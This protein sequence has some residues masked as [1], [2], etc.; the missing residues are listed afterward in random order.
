[1]GSE[2]IYKK[3]LND[4]SEIP[5]GPSTFEDICHILMKIKYPKYNFT[6]PS[7]GKGT[8]DG[9]RDGYDQLLKVKF[10]C[11]LDKD[12][13]T[14]IKKEVQVSKINGD[15]QL[16]YLSNQNI[17]DIEKNEIKADPVNTGIDLIIFGIGDLSQDIENICK[18][19]YV[20]ELY[21]LLCLDFL[22]IGE[23]YQR[24]DARPVTINYN[25]NDYKKRVVIIDKDIKFIN[26]FNNEQISENP[27]LD[28]LFS[29]CFNKEISVVKNIAFCGVGYLGKSFL[30]QKTYNTLI[31]VFSD[32]NNYS[33][34]HYIPFIKYFELKYYKQGIIEREIKNNIDP[35]LLFLDGLD[36]LNESTR[37]VLNKELHSIY[38]ANNRVRFIISGRNSSFIDFD[39]INSS[40][41]LFLEK[42]SDPY[43]Y[44]LLDLMNEY[45]NTPIADLLPIPT[46]R[47]YVVE[48]K[49][50]KD[51]KFHEFNNLLIIDNLKKDKERRDI[52]EEISARITSENNIDAVIE[53]LSNFCYKLFINK[54][55]VFTENELR[56]EIGNDKIFIL[57]IH[58]SIISFQDKDNIS[59]VSNF[60]FEYFVSNALLTKSRKTIYKI[61]VS[62]GKIKIPLIDILVLFIN[63]AQTKS[64]LLYKY[65]MKKIL[66]DNI[67]YILLCEFDSLTDKDRYE[68]F[69][70][71]FNKY[72][73]EKRS[74]YY[75]RFQPKYGP[76]KNIDNMAL[77]MQQLL[78]SMYKKNAINILISE[79]NNYLG[80]PQKDNEISFE[81]A[82]ILLVSF[83]KYKWLESE[84]VELK[85]IAIPL[86]R[87]LLNEKVFN[88][89][90]GFI[91]EEYI[92]D[93]YK[94]YNWIEGWK[95]EEWELFYLNISGRICSLLYDV[96]D[97]YDFSIKFN[98]YHCFQ[99]NNSIKE[100]LFPLLRY[101]MINKFQSGY[102]LARTV[103][104]ML[105]D[106]DYA[107]VLRTDDRIYTLTRFVEIEKLNVTEILE[108]LIFS[109]DNKI[110]SKI[111]DHYN[112][113][114]S[115]LENKLFN[116]IESIK[117]ENCELFSKYYLQTDEFK[118]SNKLFDEGIKNKNE[119]LNKYLV[120]N[121]IDKK[122][123]KW[124]VGYFLCN[125]IDFINE[126]QSLLYLNI[127]KEKSTEKIYVD[128]IYY[129]F[130]SKEHILKRN[131]V[132]INEY[133]KIFENEILKENEKKKNI[134]NKKNEIQLKNNNDISLILNQ[135]ELIEEL[136]K[137]NSYIDDYEI[138]RKER[139][140][141]GKLISLYHS[142]I[143][144]TI[145]YEFER[146]VPPV[147]SECAINIFENFYRS[148]IY[149][150][151][152]I[153]KI[154]KEFYFQE[155][156]FYIYFYWF[157]IKRHRKEQNSNEEAKDVLI[158]DDIKR[159]IIYSINNDVS[160]IFKNETI[161]YFEKYNQNKWL[162]PFFYFYD[163]VL[164]NTMLEWMTKEHILKLIVVPNPH[165]IEFVI[166]PDI[167]LNWITSVFPCIES[168]CIIEYGLKIIDKV[169]YGGSRL[170]IVN[171]FINFF[172][173][174]D[175]SNL[176]KEILEFI[177]KDTK[178]LFSITEKDHNFIE[179]Q[180]IGKFWND[181]KENYLDILFQEFTVNIITSVIRNK[182][183]ADNQYRKYV[184]Q[185]CMRIAEI[186]QKN[187]I[188]NQIEIELKK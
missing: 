30:M 138:G 90:R 158:P 185:Y 116:D 149:E 23:Y 141:L 118:I 175:Q 67:V 70:N 93:W 95:Q 153:I 81:N 9:G 73:N 43:D 168:S 74:I 76:L 103:P 68:Y 63:C 133:N 114:I 25:G 87:Y 145:T 121:V 181:C 154:L 169:E 13:K 2:T 28:F 102:G 126:E 135:N 16:F 184:L 131:E 183:K 104:E 94:E 125:L 47:N 150:F 136:T 8:K 137:I 33:K 51:T 79:I 124:H 89:N 86:I 64:K 10:A 11:S 98:F 113:L 20:P 42:Y 96:S 147:F 41:Q 60:Y 115:I 178:K 159:K 36:E 157:Y 32:K 164:E 108:L 14:K 161:E 71:I 132:I 27:L 52:S 174:Y 144:D 31:E 75:W 106:D 38:T 128:I 40:T 7:G 109:L 19:R 165:D 45:K 6:K 119:E 101:A 182:N 53:K 142:N 12:Y 4:L 99:S 48:K 44:E 3:A 173:S 107:P 21:E 49:V 22:R 58:S 148:E 180:N 160:E 92:F 61:F 179:F 129:I 35:L 143:I 46:Y 69:K 29:Y 105:T 84:Q 24:G 1:M 97:E 100:L 17:P 176:R 72:K 152:E 82:V 66:K 112:S 50:L 5:L 139:T 57:I 170:Q 110:Y 88:S 151:N 91:S 122:L 171:D 77:R 39:I 155:N 78:P 167:S 172:N 162:I 65:I 156:K 117:T 187:R 56:N 186:E 134:E 140:K 127:I 85:T 15:V 120:I 18:D 54:R 59:F 34:Y 146:I 188:I 26:L 130:H 62:R 55:Y 111:K 83:I 177:I 123:D 163:K 80:N 37:I 166:N